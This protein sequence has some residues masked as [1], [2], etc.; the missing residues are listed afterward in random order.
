MRLEIV[1]LQVFYLVVVVLRQ[2]GIGCGGGAPKWFFCGG[3]RVPRVP[4]V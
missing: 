4:G 1:A 3:K 2:G